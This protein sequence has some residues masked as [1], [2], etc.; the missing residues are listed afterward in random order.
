MTSNETA[1]YDLTILVPV[2]NEED[3]MAALSSR[4]AAYLPRA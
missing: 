1:S 4:L 3:N 2:Y